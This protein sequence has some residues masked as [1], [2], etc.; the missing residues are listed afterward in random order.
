MTPAP[1]ANPI[2][3]ANDADRARVAAMLARAF[4]DDPA[5]AYIFPDPAERARRLPRLFALLFDADAHNGLRLIAERDAAATLWR[6]PGHGKTT[7]LDM[8]MQAWPLWRA[9]GGAVGRALTVSHAID[10]HFPAGKLWYL[11]VA[12][13]DPAAQGKGIGRAIVQAGLDRI[14]AD[15]LPVYLETANER[16]LGFYAGLGFTVTQAW[17]VPRGGPRFWSMVR[18]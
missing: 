7:L 13:C 6:A 5:M 3:V 9:L 1:C 10:A 2:R 4:A 12:G 8:V 18:G 16:N 14:A 17:Q 11:H 15:G